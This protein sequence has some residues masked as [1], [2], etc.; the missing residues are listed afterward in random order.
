MAMRELTGIRTDITTTAT[1]TRT[2]RIFTCTMTVATL[3]GIIAKISMPRTSCSR[4]MEIGIS[5]RARP[6]CM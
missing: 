2:I 3:I 1:I 5:G 4:P 6:A